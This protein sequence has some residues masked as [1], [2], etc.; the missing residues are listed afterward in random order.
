MSDEQKG[1]QERTIS[2]KFNFDNV[3]KLELEIYYVWDTVR[4]IRTLCKATRGASQIFAGAK[5]VALRERDASKTG[6]KQSSK[7]NFGYPGC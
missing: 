1:L 4:E 7:I 5:R 6:S 3:T 2:I